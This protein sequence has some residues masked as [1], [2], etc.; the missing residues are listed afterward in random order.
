[1]ATPPLPDHVSAPSRDEP[2][3][4]LIQTLV[5]TH[6]FFHTCYHAQTYEAYSQKH[7]C[8]VWIPLP[9]KQWSCRT[10]AEKKISHLARRCSAALP[11][12]LLT[13][14]I[15]PALWDEPRHAFDGTRRNVPE[16]FR[17][18]RRQFGEVEYL[19]VTE[20][21]KRGW[22]HYHALVRSGFLP[23]SVV[24][25][26]WA[27]LTGATIVDL[28]KVEDRF[29][30][31]LYLVKY[32][33]KM[34]DLKWTKRHVSY[35]RG[36]FK[37][38][39]HEQRNDLELTEG[40]ILETHPATLAYHQF[41]HSEIVE[42]AYNVFT[43]NPSDELKRAVTHAPL[44]PPEEPPA[45]PSLPPTPPRHLPPP[46]DPQPPLFPKNPKGVSAPGA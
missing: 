45:P 21:T 23:H 20:L 15:D 39:P 16:L 37:D 13:L 29:Q 22:P 24:R 5:H 44:S 18:L 38:K 46:P 12:R 4:L 26:V 11:N 25:D 9:C 40:K 34:H 30:T 17:R 19:K 10:C 14:T 7:R 3:S 42:I 35:S 41:R 27:D 31:Y 28:R 36:F 8:T 33:A 2:P 6:A 1:M 43:L 32:L